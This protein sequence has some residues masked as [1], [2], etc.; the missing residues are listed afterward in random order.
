MAANP[1][2][3]AAQQLEA[4]GYIELFEL[5]TTPLYTV[6]GVATQQGEVYRWTSGIIDLRSSGTL[7]P[8]GTRTAS[9]VTLDKLLPLVEGRPYRLVVDVGDGEI[10]DPTLVSAFATV[11]IANPYG[12]GN[13]SATEITL[14]APLSAVPT[15]GSAWTFIGTKAV[16]F[17][18]NDYEPMP[19]D[20]QG[21]EWSGTGKIPRPKLRVSNIGGLAGALLLANN[22]LLGAQVTRLRTFRNFLDD[23]ET[24]DPT[25][26]Y[27]PDIYFVDRKSS[28][29]RASVELELTSA[30]DQQGLKL[31]RR[32][33]IRDTCG[34][35]YRQMV[36]DTNGVTGF[37]PGTC[38]Y[39]G[40]AFFKVDDTA[41]A[42]AAEDVC[43]LRQ[44]SCV[45]RFGAG[46]RLPFNAFP[47]LS[48]SGR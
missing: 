12:S 22:N 16:R 36:T 7:A 42:N 10:H 9:V 5:D 6:N 34:Y 11:T 26:F 27:E 20:V 32:T 13:I 35:Q 28:Q 4:D 15:S 21:F 23:G 44:A 41:T 40:G 1:V 19:I 8:S 43:G 38:P 14:A 33:M 18:G 48:I 45:V 25:A 31:P 2:L 37:V 3:A 17:R 30:L 29:T 39:S 47:G 46:A 24:P